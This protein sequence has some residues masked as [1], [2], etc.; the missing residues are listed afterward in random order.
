MSA[1]RRLATAAVLSLAAFT[2]VACGGGTTTASNSGE[3]SG[4]S[5]AGNGTGG[6]GA[7]NDGGNVNLGGSGN[8]TGAGG[9][10]ATGGGNGYCGSTL[11]GTIRDFKQSHPDFEY[12][13]ADDRGIVKNLL[14]SDHKPVYAHGNNPT[15][16]VHSQ[17]TF[18][19]WYHDVPNV[20]IKIPYTI[21]LTKGS[22]DVYT[23]DNGAFFPIDNQGWGNE[24][25]NHN[26]HFTFEI[27]TKFV[28]NG[29]EVFTFTGDDD[30]WTFI[31][32]KLAIDLGGVHGAETKSVSLDAQ[33]SAL[34]LTKGGTYSLE[35]F[36]AE[37]HTTQSHF[38]IDT[39]IASF[40][41]CGGSI[42]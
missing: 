39:T 5:G 22:G 40:V 41:D 2:C 15:I 21:T 14:G 6:S 37:R 24:G 31:N 10:S 36:S 42:Q 1:S 4:G 34:G 20:N 8:G 9:G 32:G 19:Q 30:L 38:R 17:T 7:G 3:G 12:K 23:Y 25:N 26:F 35:V 16:T 13:I 18:H 28:Y 29:G 27:H 11:T 33:A